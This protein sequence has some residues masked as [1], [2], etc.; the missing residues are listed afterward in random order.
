MGRKFRLDRLQNRSSVRL[1]A[2]ES[3]KEL[4]PTE[5]EQP[6]CP[7]V[8]YL[9]VCLGNGLYDLLSLFLKLR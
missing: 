2:T 6:P 7:L 1:C 9:G 8:G 3:P 4:E 5:Q